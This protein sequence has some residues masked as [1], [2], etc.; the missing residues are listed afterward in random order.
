MIKKSFKSSHTK[1]SS[2]TQLSLKELNKKLKENKSI[3]FSQGLDFPY[4]D[5]NGESYLLKKMKKKIDVF[6]DIGC[7]N[8]SISRFVKTLNPN[9]E[10]ILFDILDLN[11]VKFH[12]KFFVYNKIIVTN[13]LGYEKIFTYKKQNEWDSSEISS[14]Y[15]RLDY[16]LKKKDTIV[17]KFKCVTLDSYFKKFSKKKLIFVKID[18]EGG[19]MK[20][21]D[22]AKN[23]LKNFNVVGY[24]EYN[25]EAYK[26]G[27]VCF[28]DLYRYMIDINYKL[29]RITPLGLK[30]IPYYTRINENH[31]CYYFISKKEFLKSMNFKTAKIERKH[32]INQSKIYLF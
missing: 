12:S 3:L 30:E 17:K 5:L 27:G 14:L 25:P 10:F 32:G 7:N 22:G 11:K 18:V 9:I 29:Y 26:N 28:K 20:L 21:L 31:F 23:F 19:E 4:F 15:K 24:V 6:V 16:N 1:V 2:F 8:G 13:H